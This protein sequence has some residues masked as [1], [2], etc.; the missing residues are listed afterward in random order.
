LLFNQLID[1]PAPPPEPIT[2]NTTI[3]LDGRVVAR[4]VSRIQ[5]E[6]LSHASSQE[7]YTSGGIF[8]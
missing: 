6:Q 1:K 8:A 2:I 7:G 3:E 5:S 4:E